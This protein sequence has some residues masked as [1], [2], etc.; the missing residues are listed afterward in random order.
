MYGKNILV[1]YIGT[2]VLLKFDQYDTQIVNSEYFRYNRKTSEKNRTE[3]CLEIFNIAEYYIQLKLY[4][5]SRF[6]FNKYILLNT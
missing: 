2:N 4:I 1:F 6:L 3:L 5:D